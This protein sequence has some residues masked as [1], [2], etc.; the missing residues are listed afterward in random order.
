MW[1]VSEF[2][3]EYRHGKTL[4]ILHGTLGWIP[5]LCYIDIEATHAINLVSCLEIVKNRS[6]FNVTF[7]Y[8]KKFN[9]KVAD[10]YQI[11]SSRKIISF[12]F[13]YY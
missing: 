9:Y 8:S 2:F 5:L 12:R 11:V 7:K 1:N 10:R 6:L 4:I 3:I 13:E